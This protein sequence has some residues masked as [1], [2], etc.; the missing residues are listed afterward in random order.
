[1][2]PLMMEGE[3]VWHAFQK[4][5]CIYQPPADLN[6]YASQRFAQAEGQSSYNCL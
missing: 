3:T 2:P 1:M 4:V 5:G 6:V